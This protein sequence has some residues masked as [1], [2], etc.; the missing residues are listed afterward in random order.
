MKDYIYRH[1]VTVNEHKMFDC[2]IWIDVEGKEPEIIQVFKNY[3]CSASAESAAL[4]F[5]MGVEWR[6]EGYDN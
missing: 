3:P 6:G 5:I 2:K 1:D 4:A